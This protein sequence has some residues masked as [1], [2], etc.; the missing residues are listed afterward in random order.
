M[1][2]IRFGKAVVSG[3]AA[4]FAICV[5]ASANAASYYAGTAGSCG[6]TPSKTV[7]VNSTIGAA[8]AAAEAASATIVKVC[9]GSYPEQVTINKNL[10]LEGI[11][12]TTGGRG[13]NQAVITVPVSGFSDNTTD[14]S[15]SPPNP[16]AAQIY[17][18]D[19]TAV[20]ISNVVVDGS[21]WTG[22][23]PY[24]IGIY[25]QD[26]SGTL[27]RVVTRNQTAIPASGCQGG[28]GIFVESGASLVTHADGTSTVTV[29]NSS[30]HGFQKN[31]ITGNEAGT[32]LTVTGNQVR[33]QGATSGAAENGIQIAFGATGAIRS[34]T[35]IDEVWAP[36]VSLS[37]CA[38]SA[39]G[40]L[41][42]DSPGVTI[43]SNRVGNTQGGIAVVGDGAAGVFGGSANDA[44]ISSNV[45]DGTLV[46]DGI[47]V[48]GS[49][50][51]TITANTVAG[52]G[53][54]GIHLDGTCTSPA[55]TTSVATVSGNVINEACAGILNGISQT[56]GTNTFY[57]DANTILAG[58]D[59]CTLPGPNDDLSRA[60]TTD[61]GDKRPH[62]AQP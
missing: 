45:V 32:T 13:A 57:N 12:A 34:N 40:I 4:V 25:F 35:V 37:D 39:T 27:N 10:T 23:S 47:D 20:N 6:V 17:V 16:L 42:Y 31:G 54:S 14:L 24:L 5:A 61:S 21:G 11:T 46:L 1:V 22:C 50:G 44:T 36:C 48:C 43:S 56:V 7:I 15:S 62:P 33:G 41:V 26:A 53:Q 29:E 2:K 49:T 9:P 30:V 38:W 51:G 58:P 55:P 28:L 18:H 8:V 19:A 3:L 52:S 60:Q 59:K